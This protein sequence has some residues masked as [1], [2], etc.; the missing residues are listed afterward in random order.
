M[1]F[2]K[3]IWKKPLALI[4]KAKSTKDYI[5]KPSIIILFKNNLH[6]FFSLQKINEKL[7]TEQNER[8]TCIICKLLFFFFKLKDLLSYYHIKLLESIE[9]SRQAQKLD[10]EIQTNLYQ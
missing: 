4:E 7:R 10:N 2:I 6:K 5:S 8:S 3:L 9:R 1:K